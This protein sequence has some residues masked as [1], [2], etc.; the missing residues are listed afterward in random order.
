[1]NFADA[2]KKAADLAAK[3]DIA[4]LDKLIAEA[5]K[6]NIPAPLV[7]LLRVSYENAILNSGAAN[8]KER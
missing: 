3:G 8:S 4:G 5:S 2:Q 7:A 1:M 6:S